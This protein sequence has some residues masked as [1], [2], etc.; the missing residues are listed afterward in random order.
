[1]GQAATKLG[2][3][4]ACPPSARPGPFARHLFSR[5][6]AP[7]AGYFPANATRSALH[8]PRF[9]VSSP[10]GHPRALRTCRIPTVL[11][12]GRLSGA[13]RR[14]S[15]PV[16]RCRP[17]TLA[18]YAALFV[19]IVSFF[20]RLWRLAGLGRARHS[21][22]RRRTTRALASLLR[23]PL[24][25]QPPQLDRRARPSQ[26]RRPPQPRRG[27]G[28]IRVSTIRRSM[29][30][31]T[32]RTRR[33]DTARHS[34]PRRAMKTGRRGGRGER[35]RPDVTTLCITPP[36]TQTIINTCRCVKNHSA[37]EASLNML[38]IASSPSVSAS[39]LFPPR[40]LRQ[41]GRHAGLP[42]LNSTGDIHGS[43]LSSLP[44]S[45]IFRSS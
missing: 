41:R 14:P 16:Q 37:G 22:R 18:N 5:E 24:Q 4:G 8:D 6:L 27:E 30:A 38:T 21:R 12:C 25:R 10:R 42:R 33:C 36:C 13:R 40:K 15:P 3:G 45:A 28:A 32:R 26:I 11:P 1:M 35:R 29:A 43:G 39:A 2:H 23:Q 31:F 17:V 20:R 7:L 34:R 9:R 19:D 44:F